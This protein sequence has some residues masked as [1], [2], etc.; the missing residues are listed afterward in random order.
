[1]TGCFRKNDKNNWY[2]VSINQ[3]PFNVKTFELFQD[4][5]WKLPKLKN[6]P[7]LKDSWSKL[8]T[9]PWN[10]DHVGTLYHVYIEMDLLY[11]SVILVMEPDINWMFCRSHFSQYF[12]QTPLHANPFH[13]FEVRRATSPTLQVLNKVRSKQNGC[14]FGDDIF[15]CSFNE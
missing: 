15:K 9:I 14:H 11:S 5:F 4:L 2:Q 12:Q 8:R 3:S 6:F 1:M 7:W 10:K 13:S